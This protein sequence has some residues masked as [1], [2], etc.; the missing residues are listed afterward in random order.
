LSRRN[1]YRVFHKVQAAFMCNN[2]QTHWKIYCG[3]TQESA[4]RLIFILLRALILDKTVCHSVSYYH[5]CAVSYIFC[6]LRRA[7]SHSLFWFKFDHHNKVFIIRP[8]SA[9]YW[10]VHNGTMSPKFVHHGQR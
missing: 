4:P 5:R 2:Q 9:P 6:T 1:F 10:E 7:Y 3:G 8:N